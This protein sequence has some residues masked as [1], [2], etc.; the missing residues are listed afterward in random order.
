MCKASITAKKVVDAKAGESYSIGISDHGLPAFHPPGQSTDECVACVKNGTRLTFEKLPVDVQAK[1]A[2][3]SSVSGT[4]VDTGDDDADHL[5]LDDG[6]IFSLY[7]LAYTDTIVMLADE[8]ATTGASA[9]EPTED[10]ELE[11]A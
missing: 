6:T 9:A 8:P 10:K 2:I 5:E 7:D 3:A 11:P 1:Y 4:F